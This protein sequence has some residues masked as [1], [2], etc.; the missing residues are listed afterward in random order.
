M[1]SQL[2]RSPAGCPSIA[3]ISAP[4]VG[5]KPLQ[6]SM[7]VPT[8][9]RPLSAEPLG[10]RDTYIAQTQSASET[11]L[12]NPRG[13]TTDSVPVVSEASPRVPLEDPNPYPLLLPWIPLGSIR[14]CL[15]DGGSL[16]SPQG[17]NNSFMGY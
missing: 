7:P 11:R 3:P 13:L 9:P 17:E 10:V 5:S 12:Q 14:L 8:G 6:S 4:T 2:T 15:M 16:S 1:D